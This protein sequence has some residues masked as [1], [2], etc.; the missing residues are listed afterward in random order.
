MNFSSTTP[1]SFMARLVLWYNTRQKEKALIEQ[2]VQAVEPKIRMASGYRKKLGKPIQTCLE[3]CKALVATIPGPIH[4]KQTDLD[5]DPLIHAAFLASEGIKKLL[6]R[7]DATLEVSTPSTPDRFALL[8]MVHKQSTVFVPKVEGDMVLAN[9][10]MQSITFSD[11]KIVGLSTTLQSVRNK[12]EQ[13]IFHMIL[14]A[15]SRELAAKRTNLKELHEHIERLHAL[16]KIF[17]VGNHPSNYFGHSSYENIEKLKKVEKVLQESQDE[18]VH[19]REGNE[20]PEDWLTI[21]I[22]H[23]NRP[24]EIM[25]ITPITFRLD[26]RNV[27]TEKKE[28]N[29]NTLT[30]AQCSLAEEMHRDAVL[31]AYSIQSKPPH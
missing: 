3:H 6:L 22:D 15:T 1:Q 18:F 7:Q 23:L 19:A 9:T 29:A 14:E 12:L 16:S 10:P 11:H 26:W 27:V 31:I 21:L 24:E 25:R 5:A 8:T 28:D 13:L 17:S 20:T 2:V 30:L 4:L